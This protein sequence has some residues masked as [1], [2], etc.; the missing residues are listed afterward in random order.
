MTTDPVFYKIYYYSGVA[1]SGNFIEVDGVNNLTIQKQLS[2]AE[3]FSLGGINSSFN[4]NAPQEIK[5]SFE[6]SFVQ[7]DFLF[8]FT[9]SDPI[10]KFIAFDGVKYYEISNLYLDNYV[11][12][13]S[14]GSL[15][16]IVTNFTAYGENIT[17]KNQ[18]DFNGQVKSVSKDIEFELPSLDS[19]SI[20]GNFNNNIKDKFNIYQFDYNM[21]IKRQP[22]YSIGSTVPINVSQILPLDISVSI[23]SKVPQSSVPIQMPEYFSATDNFLNFDIN[24]SG[25]ASNYL[26]RLPVRNARL[27]SSEIRMSTNDI[28]DL[29]RGIIGNYGL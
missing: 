11:A 12:S 10:K 14:V 18:L 25:E 1:N 2:F 7:N 22:F 17:Q 15:P 6:R 21:S 23:T 26:F 16:R 3:Q 20:T 4:L 19:I 27:I 8:N 5:I 24:I 13:F 28:L 29:N 9:G